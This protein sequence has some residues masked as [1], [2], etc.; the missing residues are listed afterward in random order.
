MVIEYEPKRMPDNALTIKVGD[1][2]MFYSPQDWYTKKDIAETA[3]KT[4]ATVEQQ[5]D[6]IRKNDKSIEFTTIGHLRRE[7]KL[8]DWDVRRPQTIVCDQENFIKAVIAVASGKPKPLSRKIH[9]EPRT[10]K[11][12]ATKEKKA[13]NNGHSSFSDITLNPENQPKK[14][15]FLKETLDEDPKQILSINSVIESLSRLA[16]GTL[17]EVTHDIKEFLEQ[18]AEKH[19]QITR[20]EDDPRETIIKQILDSDSQSRSNR[21][22]RVN[23][24]AVL[25]ELWDIVDTHEKELKEK[26]QIIEACNRLREKG[27]DKEKVMEEIFSHFGIQMSAR[28]ESLS[29]R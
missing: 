3:G 10:Y 19:V 13:K 6:D 25:D 29:L 16:K 22:F 20:F 12:P 11:S 26:Q 27:F 2:L 7:G 8:S 9:S 4:R 1:K 23:L 24:E 28:P 17:Q 5:L 21:F 18:V 14:P 15:M